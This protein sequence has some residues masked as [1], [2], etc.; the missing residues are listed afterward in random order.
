MFLV[1]TD[2]MTLLQH[3]HER[4][5]ERFRSASEIV[6]TTIISRIEIL[7]GRFAAVVKA[8]DGEQL[9]LAQERLGQSENH[10]R[11]VP[12]LP[13]NSVAAAQFDQL[14]Q[15]KKLKKIGRRDML[16]AAISLASRATLVT[17]NLKDFRRVPGLQIENWAD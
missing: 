16:I 12:I 2:T 4:V 14:R 15:N 6:A 8:A 13:I 11:Q 17:R 9:L 7:E 3:G 1:D 5:T 10:L